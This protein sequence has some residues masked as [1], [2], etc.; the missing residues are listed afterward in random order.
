MSIGGLDGTLAIAIDARSRCV[1][2]GSREPVSS[3]SSY[4]VAFKS[5]KGG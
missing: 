3:L 5:R 1:T 4:K 2:T